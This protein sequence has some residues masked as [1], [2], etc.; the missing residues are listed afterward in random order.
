MKKLIFIIGLCS[1]LGACATPSGTRAG[2]G[3]LL[4]FAELANEITVGFE[5]RKPAPQREA[6]IE[7]PLGSP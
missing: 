6:E 2:S 3:D 5:Q 1:A 4:S 7:G